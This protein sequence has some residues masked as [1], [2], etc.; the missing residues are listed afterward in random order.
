MFTCSVL[1]F[2]LHLFFEIL[3]LAHWVRGRYRYPWDLGETAWWGPSDGR[4]STIQEKLPVVD[5]AGTWDSRGGNKRNVVFVFREVKH[6][7]LKKNRPNG[8]I[9]L[10]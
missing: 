1:L 2:L 6:I 5:D 4:I 10:E 9:L 8:G 3:Q 7:N